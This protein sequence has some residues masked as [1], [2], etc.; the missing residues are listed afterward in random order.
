MF[1]IGELNYGTYYIEET[2]V[3]G[4]FILT[5]DESGVGYYDGGS[6]SNELEKQST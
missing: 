5:V 4:Y 2:G 3:A 6:Y 1:Y